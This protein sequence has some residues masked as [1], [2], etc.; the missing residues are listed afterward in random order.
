MKI[1][2]V[3]DSL[4]YHSSARQLQLLGPTQPDAVVCCLGPETPGSASLRSAGVTVHTLGWTR[5]FDVAPLWNLSKILLD[6]GPDVI[7]AWRMPALQALAVVGRRWL[8]RTVMSAPLPIKGRLAWWDRRLLQHVRC[9]AVAGDSARDICR[10]QGITGPALHVVPPAAKL[11]DAAPIDADISIVCVGNLERENGFREA[12]WAFDILRN[13]YRDKRL[14]I[15]GAGSQL[16][17]LQTLAEGMLNNTH[18]DFPGAQEDATDALRLAEVVWVPSVANCGQQVALEAMALGKPVVASDVPCLR[19]LI[20]DGETGYLVPPGDVVALSRRT[21]ALWRD[22][23]LRQRVGETAREYV[24]R[25]F[26][27]ADAVAQWRV[28][29]DSIAGAALA[30]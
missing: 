17:S 10:N 6:V 5:W 22:A 26:T 7:H 27:L 24:R 23:A 15:V 18:V 28:V 13:L 30:A 11:P 3:I 1:L 25:H 14:Q 20:H 9:L 2:H 12:V 21:H 8:A 19:D 4:G 16:E 29:Y